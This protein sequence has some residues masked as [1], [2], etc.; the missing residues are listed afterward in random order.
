MP[1]FLEGYADRLMVPKGRHD[2]LVFDTEVA[3]LGIRKFA[4]GEASYIKYP[5]AGKVVNG[6]PVPGRTRRVTLEEVQRGRLAAARKLAQEVK[7]RARVLG[8]DLLAERDDVAAKATIPKLGE[9]IAPYLAARQEDGN[10]DDLRR[11]RASS[12][13]MARSYLEASWKP[14]HKL[15]LDEIT[16]KHVRDELKDIASSSGLPSADRARA[17][18]SGFFVWAIHQEHVAANPTLDIKDKSKSRR[19]QQ[20]QRGG[21]RT[22]LAGLR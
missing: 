16:P 10:G 2:V 9:L 20:A 22:N 17:A 15:R 4:S 12:M 18:L 1:K 7:S 5:V 21:A 14:L 13:R 6:V 3:D 11:L 8:E 19:S